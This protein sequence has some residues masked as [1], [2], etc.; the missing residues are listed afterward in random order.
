[1]VEA[2]QHVEHGWNHRQIADELNVT[3][4]ARN[5]SS[6]VGDGR[7]NGIGAMVFC[8][9]L[10]LARLMPSLLT[11]WGSPDT[12]SSPTGRSWRSSDTSVSSSLSPVRSL[13][14]GSDSFSS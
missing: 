10:L 5:N 9:A 8:R 3:A 13:R 1:V 12:P 6:Q 14:V 2:K 7:S 11:I 4:A